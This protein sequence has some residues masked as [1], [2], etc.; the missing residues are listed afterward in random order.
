MDMA[1]LYAVIVVQCGI[2]PDYFLDRMQWYEVDACLK[3]LGLS[4]RAGWEQTRYICYVTAQVNSRKQLKPSDI[5]GFGWDGEA[6]E[7]AP[8]ITGEDFERMK[9]RAK[10][11]E[12]RLA[13]SG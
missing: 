7:D 1:T 3:G 13:I 9:R 11:T 8:G 6:P 2:S 4:E 12:K 5:L 10:E